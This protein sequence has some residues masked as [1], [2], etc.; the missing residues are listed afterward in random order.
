MY[1]IN[2]RNVNVALPEGLRLLKTFGVPQVSRGKTVIEYPEPVAT[3]YSA[4][5]E[6]VLFDEERDANPFFHLMESLWILSGSREVEWIAQFNRRIREFSDDGRTFHGAYG[7]RLR[8]YG[9]V[10]DQ[11]RHVIARLQ[12]EPTTRQAVLSIWDAELDLNVITKDL[13]CNVMVLLKIR[14]GRLFTTVFNRSNDIIWGLYGANAVQFSILHEY[15]AASVGVAMGPLTHVSDSFHAYQENDY[16]QKGSPV[17]AQDPYRNGE[18]EASPLITRP[19]E[20]IGEVVRFIADPL[21]ELKEMFAEQASY[22]RNPIIRDLALPMYAAWVG[23]KTGNG[24]VAADQIGPPDWRRAC[25]EWLERRGD[26][27]EAK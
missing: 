17:G 12:D 10:G 26:K 3:V 19:D 11:L 2:A 27:L 15:L 13:P 16:W 1:V 25:L 20:L 18:V 6:R 14:G 22:Y 4:P 5:W 24:A 7:H 21:D 9:N 8:H 23:H